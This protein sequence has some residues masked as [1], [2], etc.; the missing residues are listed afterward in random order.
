MRKLRHSWLT[1]HDHPWF[2]IRP[3]SHS[4]KL[5]RLGS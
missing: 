5:L 1:S 2:S 3:G 4:L